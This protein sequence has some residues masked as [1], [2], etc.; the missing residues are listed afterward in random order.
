M[1]E[2]RLISK[3]ETKLIP[4][5]GRHPIPAYRGPEP[6]IF[7][8]YA[9]KNA[10]KVLPEIDRLRKLGYHVW[11]D[12]GIAPGNEWTNEIARALEKCAFFLVMFTPEAAAS[13]NVQNEIYY[14][15]EDKKPFLAVHLAETKLEG[16]VR[17]QI[18]KKQAILKYNMSDDEYVFKLVEALTRMG[19]KRAEENAAADDYHPVYS[20]TSQAGKTIP[21]KGIAAA[22]LVLLLVIG[23]LAVVLP[24]KEG[25]KEFSENQGTSAVETTA[26]EVVETTY[27]NKAE[28]NSV[29]QTTSGMTE[30][31]SSDEEMTE[32][33]PADIEE[34]YEGGIH[35]R[36]FSDH[37]EV[38]GY[39]SNVKDLKI[40]GSI[41]GVPMT[42]ISAMESLTATQSKLETL[43]IQEGVKEITNYS[44]ANCMNLK[45]VTLPNSL[46]S[47]DNMA[48]YYCSGLEEITIPENVGTIGYNAFLYC[49][50]LK[51]VTLP[52]RLRTIKDAAFCSCGSIEKINIPN[53]VSEI[54][55]NAFSFC[56]SLKEITIPAGVTEIPEMTF[57]NCISLSKVTFTGKIENIG[58]DA[59]NYCKSLKYIVLPAG[60]KS[61][62][63]RA[64][65]RCTALKEIVIPEGVANIGESAFNDCTALRL[66][67]LNEPL[68]KI[69][70]RL[71]YE[72]MGL[73]EIYIPA[74]VKMISHQAFQDCKNLTDIWYAGTE[75]EWES[76][77]YSCHEVFDA[78]IHFGG[79]SN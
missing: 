59:F 56:A 11:Y 3:E 45:K 1:S 74:S 22:A 52:P 16:G 58:E 79:G 12:E 40:P 25:K 71:F 19:L 51:S 65:S 7:L 13:E 53:S 50:S 66:V 46:T 69:N 75:E 24:K 17:L 28:D 30:V 21:K 33:I 26:P 44:F 35:Y 55:P 23:I 77:D 29:P 37:A 43:T 63:A 64:F 61:I 62:G 8:S 78:A 54:G 6:Y 5:K 34:F 10:D 18:G 70:S 38:I 32:G 27:Q 68:E 36:I 73:K 42:V 49:G 41:H 57:A 47:I 76:V 14:A 15:V 60:L 39:D 9:H 4:G 67:R 31:S 48:F 72:C 2:E 20:S